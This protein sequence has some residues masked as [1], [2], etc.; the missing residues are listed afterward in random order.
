MCPYSARTL[1]RAG[2]EYR[3]QGDQ[4]HQHKGM[5]I[6]FGEGR[7]WVGRVQE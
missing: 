2:Y 5:C 7:G 1:G 4:A 6:P 3:C